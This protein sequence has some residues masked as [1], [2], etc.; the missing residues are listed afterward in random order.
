[1]RF[2]S[3]T[4]SGLKQGNWGFAFGGSCDTVT[5]AVI[6][7]A[8][9]FISLSFTREVHSPPRAGSFFSVFQ[10]CRQLQHLVSELGADGD[11]VVHQLSLF[12]VRRL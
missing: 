9:R 1:M 2:G 10:V 8:V 6:A 12:V 5:V 3:F 4:P 11:T 7:V